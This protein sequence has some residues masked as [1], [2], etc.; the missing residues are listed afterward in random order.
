MGGNRR[1][2]EGRGFECPLLL[3]FEWE[4]QT[5]FEVHEK[6]LYETINSETLQEVIQWDLIVE[7]TVL[8]RKINSFVMEWK[9]RYGSYR[10]K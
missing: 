8:N 2:R 1:E 4:E 5:Y 3:V 10:Y 7:V 9:G 6:K